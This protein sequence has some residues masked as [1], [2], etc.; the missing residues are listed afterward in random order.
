MDMVKI[1]TRKPVW[2]ASTKNIK[3]IVG[4]REVLRQSHIKNQ[5]FF[6]KMKVYQ[7]RNM[8]L[9]RDG[10][11][12]N[13]DCNPYDPKKQDYNSNVITPSVKKRKTPVLF[14]GYNVDDYYYDGSG[15]YRRPNAQPAEKK[16]ILSRLLK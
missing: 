1:K 11:P 12:N 2:S 10:V 13:K 16:G 4:S 15:Y 14:R 3:I 9:D 6:S 8:D 5:T 7:L